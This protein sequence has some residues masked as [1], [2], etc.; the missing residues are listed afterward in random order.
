MRVFLF[1]CFSI[2]LF[3]CQTANK[4]LDIAI[5]THTPEELTYPSEAIPVSETQK[6]LFLTKYF[7]PWTLEPQALLAQKDAFPGKDS[8]YIS[9]YLADSTWYGENKKPHKQRERALVHANADLTNFPNYLKRAI[10]TANTDLRRVPTTRPGFDKYSKAGEGF[11]FDYFQETMVWANTPVLLAHITKDKQWG[12]VMSPFY[13]GWIRLHDL[14]LTDETFI[15]SWMVG[16]YATPLSDTLYLQA[17]NSLK[18][19]D[20]KLGMLIPY[21]PM[22]EQSDQVLGYY[23]VADEYLQATLLK[24]EMDKASLAFADHPM[25]AASLKALVNNFLGKPYGWG[26]YLENRDCSSMI[27]D[28]LA[29]YRIWVPRDSKDQIEIGEQLALEGTADEKIQRIKE[30]GIPF[31]TIL[32]KKGHN[33]LYVGNAPNGEPLILHAIWGLKTAFRDNDLKKALDQYPLEG[34]HLADDHQLVGRQVIGEAVITSVTLGM[35]NTAITVPLIDDIYAMT[36]I[37]PHSE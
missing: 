36:T 24:A 5:V 7:L 11:P 19:L 29:T 26:G 2:V 8:D 25:N 10:T 28:L 30:K 1:C 14:A 31:L 16:S 18:T 3:G 12:Y 9:A 34:M 20:A 6:A 35:E 13:K 33:M 23:A 37:L 21:E 4:D 32:R 22:E 27:R 17:P 15:D